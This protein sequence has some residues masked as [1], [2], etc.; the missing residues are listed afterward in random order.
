MDSKYDRLLGMSEMEWAVELMEKKA[1]SLKIP[2][3]NVRITPREFA[4]E[5]NSGVLVGFCQLLARGLMEPDYPNSEFIPSK[6]LI[7]ILNKAWGTNYPPPRHR[8]EMPNCL[9]PN[10][11]FAL[12]PKETPDD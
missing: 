12:K 1:I 7:A 6:S 2:I 4:D 5:S 9:F 8:G 11:T 3:S 10:E